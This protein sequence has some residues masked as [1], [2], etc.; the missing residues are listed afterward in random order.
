V[1]ELYSFIMKYLSCGDALGKPV[2]LGV[3]I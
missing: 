2:R 3:K 1:S